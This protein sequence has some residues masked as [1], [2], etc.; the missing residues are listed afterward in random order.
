VARKAGE[1]NAINRVLKARGLPGLEESGAVAALAFLVEDHKHFMELL[2][3]CEPSL[4]RDMY[5]AMSPHLR[6]VAFPLETYVIAAKE[7][8]E[9]AQLPVTDKYGFLQPY[10]MPE[11]RMAPIKVTEL[12]ARCSKCPKETIFVGTSQADVIYTMRSAGWAYDETEA[13]AHI[14]PDCLEVEEANAE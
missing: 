1:A 11:V 14:C 8:A 10:S 3:A 6:F 7:H 5:E 13:R 4:R 9:A 12:W 2:R